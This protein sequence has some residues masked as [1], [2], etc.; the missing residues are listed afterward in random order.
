MAA[1]TGAWA[2]SQFLSS[3]PDGVTASGQLIDRLGKSLLST[4]Q[5]GLSFAEA[6]TQAGL[7]REEFLTALGPATSSGLV[8]VFDDGGQQKLRLTPAGLSLY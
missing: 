8:E 4:G 5:A 3:S 6:M 2:L 1:N 7:S